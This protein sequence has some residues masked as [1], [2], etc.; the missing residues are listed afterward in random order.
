MWAVSIAK[1]TVARTP[2]SLFKDFSIEFTQEEQ[3]IPVID[4]LTCLVST[5]EASVR[6]SVFLDT[7][8]MP[9]GYC[10]I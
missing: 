2:G 10:K 6:I 7:F 8:M 3:V 1:L 9:K 4:K 5:L